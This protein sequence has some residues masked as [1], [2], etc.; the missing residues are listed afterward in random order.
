M[1][2]LLFLHRRPTGPRQL[3]ATPCRSSRPDRRLPPRVHAANV[4][5]IYQEEEDEG[6]VYDQRGDALLCFPKFGLI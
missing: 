3:K 5:I 2:R 4:D 1:H 6:G